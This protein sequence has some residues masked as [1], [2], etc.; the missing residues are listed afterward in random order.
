MPCAATTNIHL[1]A[2]TRD[3]K[4]KYTCTHVFLVSPQLAVELLLPQLLEVGVLGVK[5]LVERVVEARHRLLLE[6]NLGVVVDAAA[7]SPLLLD[8]D[9]GGAIR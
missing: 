9:T 1:L 8:L 3:D 2:V 6:R 5:V 4:H 7:P